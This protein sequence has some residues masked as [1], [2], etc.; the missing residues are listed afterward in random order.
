M[1]A[2]LTTITQLGWLA[3]LIVIFAESGLMVGFFLPGDSLLFV[4]G[5][6]VQR[7]IFSVPIGV[8]VTCLF[9][10]AALGNTTGYFLGKKFGRRLFSRPDSRF[11]RHEYLM[12]AEKFYEKNGPKAIILAMFI[13]IV[14]AFAPVVAGIAQMSYRKFIVFN[15][16][17][18]FIWVNLFTLLGYF[19]GDIIE[20]L[21]INVEL[22]ALVIILISLLP[23]IIHLLQQPEYRAK[24]RHH[25]GR[26]TRRKK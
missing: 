17:G 7:E 10:A 11:F 2:I 4:A 8:F 23:G 1:E 19:A 5:T 20:R 15:L 14:R 9:F 21:G 22:A 25:A 3:V 6:L 16:I 18:A 12:Q 26:I 24:L 13:P